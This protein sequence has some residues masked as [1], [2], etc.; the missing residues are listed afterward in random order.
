M[1]RSFRPVQV[2]WTG[3]TLLPAASEL[4]R[5]DRELVVSGIYYAYIEQQSKPVSKFEAMYHATVTQA[6]EHLSD[7]QRIGLPSANHYRHFLLAKLGYATVTEYTFATQLD[8]VAFI[9]SEAKHRD[10]G[11][12]P[13]RVF[14]FRGCVVRIL[15]PWSQAH[16]KTAELSPIHNR[17][18]FKESANKVL[19]LISGELGVTLQELIDSCRSNA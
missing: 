19:A 9:K 1:S 13:Y 8:A 7:E 14:E 15:K 2:R 16:S 5:L 10:A 6:F 18:G 11:I 17:Q 4:A 12:T 3:E